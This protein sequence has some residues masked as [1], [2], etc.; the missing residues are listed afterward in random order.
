MK[1][2]T[3]SGF[4]SNWLAIGDMRMWLQVLK[5]EIDNPKTENT[6]PGIDPL[7]KENVHG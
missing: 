1:S 5:S 4:F 2:W 7:A 6:Q 3:D